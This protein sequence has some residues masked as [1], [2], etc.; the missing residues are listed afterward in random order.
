MW[1]KFT[2]YIDIELRKRGSEAR[3]RQY[4]QLELEETKEK[5]EDCSRISGRL[6]STRPS[7]SHYSIQHTDNN[8]NRKS[9]WHT[10]ASIHTRKSGIDNPGRTDSIKA[11]YAY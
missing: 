8:E 1:L 4:R 3:S 6:L 7:R 10:R 2:Y 9:S 11:L 5:G